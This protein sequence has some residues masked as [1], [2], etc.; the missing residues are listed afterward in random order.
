MEKTA[1]ANRVGSVPHVSGLRPEV[2]AMDTSPPKAMYA[3]A[4]NPPTSA[5]FQLTPAFLTPVS[6]AA[7]VISSGALTATLIP[8]RNDLRGGRPTP[9]GVAAKR[10]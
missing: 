4:R 7:S 8:L 6:T 5:L 2:T 3:P 10:F 9:V 1:P